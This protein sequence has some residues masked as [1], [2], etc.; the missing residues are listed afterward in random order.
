M[1]CSTTTPLASY[2]TL[3][4]LMAA[5]NSD[6]KKP[7]KITPAPSTRKRTTI[8]GAGSELGPDVYVRDASHYE[9]TPAPIRQPDGERDSQRWAGR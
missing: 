4:R 3:K 7:R 2:T 1:N 9:L 6:A 8:S 5:I